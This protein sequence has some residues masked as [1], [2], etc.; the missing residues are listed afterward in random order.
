MASCPVTYHDIFFSSSSALGSQRRFHPWNLPQP[1]I[2]SGSV[3]SPFR[4]GGKP[5]AWS[6]L[7]GS[8]ESWFS[9]VDGVVGRGEHGTFRLIGAILGFPG[10][11]GLL[12]SLERAVE[13][14]CV[15][16]EDC[17]SRSVPRGSVTPVV[18]VK[19][20]SLIVRRTP[21]SSRGKFGSRST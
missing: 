2:E 4:F 3:L 14:C 20:V 10:R 13:P 21:Q 19:Q 17:C 6:F 8:P 12:G 11:S 18:E 16:A 9:A 15:G 1:L 5:P 7:L